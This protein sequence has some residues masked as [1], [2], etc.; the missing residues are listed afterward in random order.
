M[1]I[2]TRK[3]CIAPILDWTD[4]HYRYIMRLI[5]RHTILYTEMVTLNAILHGNKECLVKYNPQENQVT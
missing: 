1:N 4:R 3:I 5:T 2:P